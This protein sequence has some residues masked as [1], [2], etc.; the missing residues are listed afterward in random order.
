MRGDDKNTEGFFCYLS[1]E[2]VVPA[3]HP[4]RPI[5]RMAEE[6]LQQLSSSF[7]KM[8]S[9][10]GRPSIAPEK[11]TKA[12]L[13]QTLYSIKSVRMLMEQLGYNILY[14]WFVGLAIDDKVWDHSTF[15]QNQERFINSDIAKAFLEKIQDQAERAGLLSNE[16]FSVD[17]TLIEA[18]ASIKSFQRKDKQE[19]PTCNGRNDEVDFHGE[20]RSN[21]THKST[22]DP[23]S[24]LFKKG[25]G[26]EAK[27]SYM[28]HVLMENRNGLI[29]NTEL[30]LAT[31]TAE[32]EAAEK[33]VEG[34]PGSHR[35]TVAGDKN[36]D[37]KGFV[38]AMRELNVTP[39]VAQNDKNRS[40]AIDLRT[41]RHEGYAISQRYRKRIEEIFGWMKTV[42]NLRKTKYRGQAKVSWHFDFTSAAY[43]LV[44][45]R[46]LGVGMA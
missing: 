37:T 28:G 11:L 22:T 45:M 16:H 6:A 9:H 12:L 23:D 25:K 42:G 36:Y 43:N 29:I 17:G 44:R 32:R 26:K 15:S 40:S 33:M 38:E 21:E 2:S 31:G 7:E 4:L 10:T 35:I 30:T 46:N 27:L 1:A 41:T 39:H 19:Q 5:R 24:R 14:K 18:W 8:Y 13:L 20:K 34:V 3:D